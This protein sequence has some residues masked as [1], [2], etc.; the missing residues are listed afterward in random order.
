MVL[1]LHNVRSARQESGPST[2]I[3]AL[4]VQLCQESGGCGPN[5]SAIDGVDV[6]LHRS[7]SKRIGVDKHALAHGSDGLRAISVDDSRHRFIQVG[8]LMVHSWVLCPLE[9]AFDDVIN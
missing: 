1:G 4:C 9:D 6:E 8:V 5:S 2:S 3:V 7:S